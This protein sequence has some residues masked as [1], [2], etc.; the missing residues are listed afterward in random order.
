MGLDT[1]RAREIAGGLDEGQRGLL[2]SLPAL[3]DAR[4]LVEKL[5]GMPELCVLE[6]DAR[7]RLRWELTEI[8]RAV[9]T[10]LT[11]KEA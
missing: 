2:L 7:P 10:V 6:G 1:T 3:W 4:D 11:E 8:G 5:Q 9:A